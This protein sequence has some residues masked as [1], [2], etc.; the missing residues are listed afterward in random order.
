MRERLLHAPVWVLGLV[1]GVL[2]G[3][4]WT[5]W[6]RYGDGESWTS[7]LA[8]GAV[9]GVVFGCVMGVVQHRQQRGVRDAAVHSPEGLSKRVRRAAFRGPVPE[10]PE[11][12]EAARVLA[13]AQLAQYERQRRWAPTFF[14]FVALLS[15]ALAVT[16]NPWW[17]G[18]VVAWIIA[19]IGHPWA[20]RRLSR[21]AALLGAAP[22]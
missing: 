11:V 15:A 13:L 16:N 5:A 21:R 3:L 1:N 14:V 20:Q 9:L 6:S 12:R 4:F 18:A 22:R 10:Q 7:S 8:T 2:F 19:S 17:W